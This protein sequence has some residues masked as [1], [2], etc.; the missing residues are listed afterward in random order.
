M[1]DAH[2]ELFIIFLLSYIIGSISPSLLIGKILY[3]TDIREFGSKNLGGSNAGRILGK[4]IGI[5][6]IILDFLKGFFAVWLTVLLFNSNENVALSGLSVILG[7]LFPLFAR[8]RGGKG[9]ATTGGVLFFI[10][11]ILIPI[12]LAMILLFWIISKYESLATLLTFTFLF[13]S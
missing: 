4:K 11:P 12:S 5:V 13:I 6:V 10:K 9:V 2:I 7:H 1:A 3:K 8:F